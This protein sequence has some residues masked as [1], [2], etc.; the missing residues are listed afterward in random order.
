[1]LSKGG[2]REGERAGYH[3]L[4]RA[5]SARN[6]MKRMV[7]GSK[8]HRSCPHETETSTVGP[9]VR[10]MSSPATSSSCQNNSGSNAA[11]MQV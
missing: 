11:P 7:V 3:F 1:M 8:S 2:G 4:Q 5:R 6:S 9:P 10:T